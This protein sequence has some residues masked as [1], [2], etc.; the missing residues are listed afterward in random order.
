NLRV[1]ARP[2][3]AS[4]THELSRVFDYFPRL[5]DRRRAPAGRLSGGEQQMLALGRA[6]IARPRF[7]AVDEPSL[8][9]SPLLVDQVYDILLKLRGMERLTLLIVEQ[10]A[11][12]ALDAADRLYVLRNGR[13]EW[14]G[15][16]SEFANL[17]QLEEAYFGVAGAD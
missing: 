12:R 1:A 10:S 7:I 3:R 5:A 13:I 4:L 2:K 15:A 17:C 14:S 8:G 16:R 6:L 9:L 11:E